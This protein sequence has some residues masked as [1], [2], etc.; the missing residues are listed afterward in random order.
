MQRTFFE[1]V[2]IINYKITQATFKCKFFLEKNNHE[3]E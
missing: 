1:K 2:E 3:L